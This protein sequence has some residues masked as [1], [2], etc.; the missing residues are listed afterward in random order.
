MALEAEERVEEDGEDGAEDEHRLC[1]ALPV[2]LA[3]GVGPD[4]PVEAA[5]GRTEAEAACERPLPRPSR[6]GPLEAKRQAE[7]IRATA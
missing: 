4:E 5:L 3:V 7:A 6:P 2:L 1:V